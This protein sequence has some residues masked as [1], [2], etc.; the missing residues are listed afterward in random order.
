MAAHTLHQS[1]LREYD[2]RGVV[3]ETLSADDAYAIGRSFGSIVSQNSGRTV[4][5]GHDGRHS[6]PGFEK[7]LVDGLTDCGLEVVRIGLGG[8]PM[9]YFSVHDM[10]ADAGIMVSGSHNP[11]DFNGFKM[12]LSDRPFFGSDIQRLGAVAEK[13]EWVSG[14]GISRNCEIIEKYVAR[15][16]TDYTSPRGLRVAW[17]SGNG[18]A[19]PAVEKLIKSLPGTHY[20]LNLEVDG[21]FPNHHPDPTIPECLEQLQTEVTKHDCDLGIALDG[22]GDRIGV[23][24]D[25]GE[26]LWGDQLMV[27]FAADVLG[28][29]PNS[30]IIADVKAS[31]ILFD[32]ISK[33]G[34]KP[35]MWRTGHS[36]IK[37]RM[38]E[39]GASLAGEMSGH[40]FFA[41]KW[42]GFDDGLYAAIRLLS[43]LGKQDRPLS[44][45]RA[46]LPEVFNTPEIR[47]ACEDHRKF[48]VVNRVLSSIKDGNAK[49][50]DV[51]G[52]RVQTNDGWWLLRASNTEP[53]L[54]ARCESNSPGGLL[55]LQDTLKH[56]L[57]RNGVKI[58][59]L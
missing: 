56:Q 49:I 54:V 14:S 15:I 20:P 19:G 34:G 32:E 23:I 50:I 46:E 6:S 48:D 28:S 58:T 52:I 9:L 12:V 27:M 39:T 57:S 47:I 44:E 2:I 13:N 45:I 37:S 41:D 3:G 16:L 38:L 35:E 24:D 26:I 22:D 7:V 29:K 40:I 33:M 1:I 31:Q 8:T 5:V 11:P 18:A 43:Y 42:F 25:Q 51:D 4:A 30:T 21:D 55:R 17:D 53:V 59:K 36:L 10:A